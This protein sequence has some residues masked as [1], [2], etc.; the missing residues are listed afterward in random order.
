MVKLAKPV[1][2]ERRC[3]SST[4]HAHI[5]LGSPTRIDS[6]TKGKLWQPR[7]QTRLQDLETTRTA[8]IK[9]GINCL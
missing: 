8:T 9:L 6:R 5:S 1:Q 3:Q 2:G 7:V 4:L